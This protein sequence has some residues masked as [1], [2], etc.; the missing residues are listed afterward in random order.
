MTAGKGAAH[1]I[2]G[3][4]NLAGSD[5]TVPR[6]SDRF[7]RPRRIGC[8]LGCAGY[9]HDPGCPVAERPVPTG[10]CSLDGRCKTLGVAV[11]SDPDSVTCGCAEAIAAHPDH[12]RLG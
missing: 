6:P 1:Q 8:L 7:P 9:A 12:G 2:D 3:G 10:P 4:D 5:L 11:L